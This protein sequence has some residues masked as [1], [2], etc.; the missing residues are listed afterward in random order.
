MGAAVACH[1]HFVY[2]IE[3][4]KHVLE[5]KMNIPNIHYNISVK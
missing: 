4:A 2:T 5:R 1:T 3:R